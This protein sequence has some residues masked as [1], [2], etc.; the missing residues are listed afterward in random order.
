MV[1]P[2]GSDDKQYSM[3][4]TQIRSLSQEDTLEKGLATHSTILAWGIPWIE[5]PVCY[6]PRGLRVA[7]LFISNLC[8]PLFHQPHKAWI[9]DKNFGLNDR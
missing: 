8:L 4:E 1:V 9:L 5:E 2:G 6:S 3:Q 7:H